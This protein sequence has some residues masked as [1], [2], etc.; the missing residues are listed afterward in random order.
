MP[1]GVIA[2]VT[3]VTTLITMFGFRPL[4][5][6]M[7]ASSIKVMSDLADGAPG[8]LMGTA[9][10]S[11]DSQLQAPIGPTGPWL[12]LGANAP[13]RASLTEPASGSHAPSWANL[14]DHCAP[15][16]PYNSEF[17]YVVGPA[18]DTQPERTIYTVGNSH[19]AQIGAA[20]LEV[21]DR[22]TNWT[23]RSQAVGGCPFD[24]VPE[25]QNPCQEMWQLATK[26]I[27]E[28]QPD[29]VVVM[30]TRSTLTGP[31]NLLPG[32]ADWII[33]IESKTSSEVVA[34]RDTPRFTKNPMDCAASDGPASEACAFPADISA[35]LSQQK[36]LED[37]G[38]TYIDLNPYFCPLSE[39]RPVIGGV[40][41]Y[42]D[43]NH[44][45][46][47]FWRTLAWK[48]SIFINA[49]I[50]WWPQNPYL[51]DVLKTQ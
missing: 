43:T 50:D 39:C 46:A 44:I 27:L 36:F 32:L 25:P 11:K 37:A 6:A 2:I 8:S 35:N 22:R 23:L 4:A 18:A 31:E 12:T 5:E 24:Y 13:N 9:F 47:D 48:L 19:S 10:L 41:V 40:W 34:V 3:A 45:N 16:D 49:E 15:S 42:I 26:Y 28:Q 7:T 38:A 30:G 20:L 51:G 33:M 14:G 17:C 1:L 21:V 29:L